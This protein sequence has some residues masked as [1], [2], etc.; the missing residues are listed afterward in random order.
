MQACASAIQ[1]CASAIQLCASAIQLCASAIQ[2]CS[3]A[4]QLCASAIQLCAS[5]IQLCASAIQLRARAIQL[6][7]PAIEDDESLVHN[8]QP[9]V[10]RREAVAQRSRRD[11]FD[12]TGAFHPR[13]CPF[14]RARLSV[15]RCFLLAE[16]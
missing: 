11:R 9:G 5:A 15:R 14:Y 4:I 3:S 12:R 13:R 8:A 1:L 10:R 2:L 16:A 6:C 7:A